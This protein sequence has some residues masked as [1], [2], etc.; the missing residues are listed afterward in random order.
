[1]K[2]SKQ[3]LKITPTVNEGWAVHIYDSD[4][5]LCCTLDSSHGRVFGLGLVL[6][7]IA[8]VVGTNLVL[9]ANSKVVE[10]PPANTVSSPAA[11][12][13]HSARDSMFWID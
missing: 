1:M 13:P 7:I 8:A 6:G 4:R 11:D 9:P 2:N 12:Y 5:H 3:D 10:S